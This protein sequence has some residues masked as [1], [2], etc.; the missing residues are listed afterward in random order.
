MK[1]AAG[2]LILARGFFRPTVQDAVKFG[3]R[4][5]VLETRINARV[6]VINESECRDPAWVGMVMDVEVGRAFFVP[7]VTVCVLG[8]AAYFRGVS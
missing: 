1:H 4:N 7:F 2:H 5:F 6:F 3:E 8:M